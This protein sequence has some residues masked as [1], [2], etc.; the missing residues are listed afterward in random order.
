MI[1]AFYN[2]RAGVLAQEQAMSVIANNLSN[3]NTSGYKN[4]KMGFADLL[5]G[6][7]NMPEGQDDAARAGAGVR[8]VQVAVSFAQGAME[9]TERELDFALTGEGFFAVQNPA[10][11][12]VRYTR[13]GSFRKSLQTDGFYLATAE[14]G[15]VLNRAGAPIRFAD[16]WPASV[17]QDRLQI[18]VYR[19]ANPYGLSK[20]GDNLY[21][22]TDN[23]RPA[24]PVAAPEVRQGYLERANV[25]VAAEMAHVI[26][27][28]R[29]FQINARMVSLS[30]EMEQ[31]LNA[32]RS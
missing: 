14:G 18:G 5:Y 7:M 29:A 16:D 24:A 8:P 26:E 9:Q 3:V 2:A 21:A 4:E 10:N 22:A 31:Q 27:T 23:S 19:F 30:D 17:G 20:N 25:D 28:Q 15:L 1:S 13:D 12:E 6:N 11:G 32:L